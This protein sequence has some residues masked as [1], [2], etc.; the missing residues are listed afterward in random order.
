MN[1]LSKRSVN[2]LDGVKA[3][4]IAIMVEGIKES[5]FDF[6]I[7][8]DGGVRTNERQLV[9]YGFGRTKKQLAKKKIPTNL[10]RP[11]KRKVTWTLHS[12]HKQN[13]KDGMGHAVDIF[14]YVNGKASWNLVYLMPIARH[15]QRVAKEKFGINLE[16]GYDLWGKDGAHF[17]IR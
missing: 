16:W 14:A 7:P 3:V 13:P 9:L 4:L 15:L 10:A 11:D 5:P 2:R 8:K 17:Q 1:K 12:L 6:G